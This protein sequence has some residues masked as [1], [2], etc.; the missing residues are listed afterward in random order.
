MDTEFVLESIYIVFNSAVGT[1]V[2]V[3]LTLLALTWVTDKLFLS[4]P[5]WK[6]YQGTIVSGVKFAEKNATDGDSSQSKLRA[7]MRFVLSDYADCHRGKRPSRKLREE[8]RQGIQIT[9]AALER[10]GLLKK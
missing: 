5:K 2:I 6:K 9:H 3:G 4:E 8:I 10:Q 1:A 7:A